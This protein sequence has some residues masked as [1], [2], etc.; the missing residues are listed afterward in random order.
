[1]GSHGVVSKGVSPK[2][3]GI[4]E[5]FE[6]CSERFRGGACPTCPSRVECM[7]Y[8]DGLT[9][10]DTS[11]TS[12]TINKE[13]IRKQLEEYVKSRRWIDGD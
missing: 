13:E 8:Y 6:A 1:M 7:A 4:I 11:I 3:E 10:A 12:R 2:F 5:V 9:N